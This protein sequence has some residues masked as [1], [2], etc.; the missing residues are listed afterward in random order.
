MVVGVESIQDSKLPLIKANTISR[1]TS[2]GANK[3]TYT[4]AE[5]A[6]RRSRGGRRLINHFRDVRQSRTPTTEGQNGKHYSEPR[7]GFGSF[8]GDRLQM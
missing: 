6:L 7:E 4:D 3:A 2:I 8:H 1:C 5:G